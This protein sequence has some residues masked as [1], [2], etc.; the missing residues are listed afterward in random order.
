MTFLHDVL[1]DGVQ[2]CTTAN[3]C[4]E[5]KRT[6]RRDATAAFSFSYIALLRVH[7]SLYILA[8]VIDAVTLKSMTVRKILIKNDV[9]MHTPN[10]PMTND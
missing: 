2:K 6:L 4:F 10:C 8:F 7:V 9:L 1:H 3:E 5:N